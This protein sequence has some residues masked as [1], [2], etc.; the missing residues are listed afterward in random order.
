MLRHS[1]LGTELDSINS[2]YTKIR[3]K[4]CLFYQEAVYDLLSEEILIDYQQ[5]NIYITMEQGGGGH[6]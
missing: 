4:N 5:S 3:F 6:C 1:S 2:E